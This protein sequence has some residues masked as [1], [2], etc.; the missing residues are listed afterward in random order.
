MIE[1]LVYPG[2][3]DPITLGHLDVI[4]RASG[5]C[6][7]LIIAVLSNPSKTNLFSEQQRIAMIELACQSLSC[8]WV[9]ESVSGLLV[10]YL[11]SLDVRHIVRGCRH[12]GDFASEMQLANMNQAMLSEMETLILP[13]RSPLSHIHAS[14]VRQVIAE[15]GAV[16]PFVPAEVAAYIQSINN[17]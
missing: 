15:K 6:D 8:H 3:F 9:V 14:L 12:A 10:D 5:L 16:V 2:S 11:K 13:A 1:R 7:Q 17:E 4:V